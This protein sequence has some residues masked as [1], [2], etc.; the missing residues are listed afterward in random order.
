M[1]N[2]TWPVT[3]S[4][5][6]LYKHSIAATSELVFFHP[7][8]YRAIRRVCKCL[9]HATV[10]RSVYCFFFS[11]FVLLINFFFLIEHFCLHS[12]TITLDFDTVNTAK[13]FAGLH[14]V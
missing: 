5:R 6:V 12:N 13:S 7:T 1:N 11:C 2:C 10:T 9:D 3:L 14:T 4:F 8:T